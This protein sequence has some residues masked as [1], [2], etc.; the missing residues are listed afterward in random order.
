ME[1]GSARHPEEGGGTILELNGVTKRFGGLT[2]VEDITLRVATAEI[3][4]IIGPN[5]AGKT[6][7]FNCIAGLLAPSGGT[8]R[9]EGQ[10][11]EG[12]KPHEICRLGL[13]KT[14]QI[15]R[16]FGDLDVLQNVMIGAFNRTSSAVEAR[17]EAERVLELSGLDHK[18]THLGKTLTTSER[19]RLELARTLATGPKL[20]LLDE[21]MAGLNSTEVGHMVETLRLVRSSGVTLL[22]IEHVMQAITALSDRIV[23]LNHGRVIADGTPAAVTADARVIEA[24]LGQDVLGADSQRD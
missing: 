15:V 6:T 5:G 22:A 12:K 21:V 24:Y 17:R 13:T 18:W 1:R 10:R 16:P 9:F 2:A 20:L 7:L 14:F 11:I 8:V 19:K 23:V 3:V 4:G